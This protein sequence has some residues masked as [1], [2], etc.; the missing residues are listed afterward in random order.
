MCSCI[1]IFLCCQ[2]AHRVMIMIQVLLLLGGSIMC[3][4]G[5]CCSELCC[6][7]SVLKLSSEPHQIALAKGHSDRNLWVGL[8]LE[9]QLAREGCQ[10]AYKYKV[11]LTLNSCG[12]LGSLHRARRD[13]QMIPYYSHTAHM[14]HHI[15][16]FNPVLI[17]RLLIINLHMDVRILRDAF[18]FHNVFNIC[19]WFRL[20]F[21]SV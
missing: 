9:N 5:Q 10:R 20:C 18:R 17:G 8:T 7:C 2:K 3:L 4:S 6:T 19:L 21:S 15:V 16:L 12:T 1:C 14:F 13:V 11:K